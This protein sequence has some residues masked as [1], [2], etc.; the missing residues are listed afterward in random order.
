MINCSG[1]EFFSSGVSKL[2]TGMLWLSAKQHLPWWDWKLS[3]LPV[4][5]IDG[6]PKKAV[7][8][9]VAALDGLISG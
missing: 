8:G 2:A 9:L 3:Y 1:G 6:R 4:Y 7:I 5:E